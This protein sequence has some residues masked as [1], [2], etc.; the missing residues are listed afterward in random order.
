MKTITVKTPNKFWQAF[1]WLDA[2]ASKVER[3]AGFTTFWH[4]V[5]IRP[6]YM[7][8]KTI[9]AHEL[10]HVQQIDNLGLINFTYQYLM[11]SFKKGYRNNKFEVEARLNSEK[12]EDIISKY[13]IVYK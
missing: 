7:E 11:E 6:E 5:L 13:K 3:I 4:T 9:L 12:P 8:S 1:L 10:T 2:K